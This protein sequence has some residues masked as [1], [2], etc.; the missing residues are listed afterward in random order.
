[1]ATKFEVDV[2]LPLVPEIKTT[3]RFTASS[4]IAFG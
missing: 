3:S 2:V 4:L 1:M